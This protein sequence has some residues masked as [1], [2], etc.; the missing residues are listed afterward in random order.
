MPSFTLRLSALLLLLI[1][2]SAEARRYALILE[3]PPAARA[4]ASRA[5][6]YS[7]SGLDRR[8]RI[9]QAQASL[10][11]TLRSRRLAITGSVQVLLNAVFVEASADREAELRSLPGVRRVIFLPR[12]RPLLDRAVSLVNAPGAWNALG[13]VQNAG[14]GIK[15]GIIDTGI[16][17]THPAFQD[18]GLPVPSGFPICQGSDCAYTNHK[19]IVARSYVAQLAAGSPPGPQQSHPDDLSPADRSGHGTAVAMV[20]AGE[21]STGPA[22]AITGMAPKAYLGNYK[23]FGSPGVNGFSSGDVIMMALEQAL[24]DGMDIAVLSL[25]GPAFSGPLDTGAACG[26]NP[27]EVCDPEA[28]AVENAIQAGMMVVVAAGNSGDAGQ[29]GITLSTIGSPGTA[30]S[31]LTVGASSNSHAFV[32]SVQ[33]PGSDV[34]ANLR[35]F[36]AVFGDGALP[37]SPFTA[38]A[39][40]VTQLGD[41]GLACNAL[42]A[43]SLS[44]S[45]ALIQRGTCTFLVKVQNA[46]AAGATGVVIYQQNGVDALLAPGGLGGISIP[47]LMVGYTDG[48]ALKTFLDANPGHSVTLNPGLAEIDVSNGNQVASFSA[49]GPV[50]GSGA[51]KP[52]LLAVGTNLYMA[53]D[54][55]DP[56]ADLYDP[57][58]FTVASGTSFSAPMAAGGVALVKQ[59]H[60]SYTPGQLKSAVVNNATQDISESDGT[61]P[62]L[63]S[64]GAGKLNAGAA[65][66]NTVTIEPATL[67]F[68]LITS[69]STFP[70]TQQL[71][72]TNTGS[73]GL[74]LT[75]AVTPRSGAAQISLDTAS[76]SLP[77]GQ[78]RTV[79]ATLSGTRPGTGS[80][81]GFLTVQGAPSPLVVPY[82]YVVGDG[83]AYDIFS[84]FG[85]GFDGTVGQEH[86]DGGIAFKVVDRYGVGVPNLPVTFRAIQGGG[87]FSATYPRTDSN[88][89]AYADAFLGPTTGAQQ[90][91]GEVAGLAVSF[92]GIARLQPTI[93]TNGVVNAAS[94]QVGQGIAPGS[95][96][97][98][99]GSGLSDITDLETTTT[100]P[101][102]LAQVSVS[103]DVPSAGLSLPGRIY[104]VSPGQVNVQV[105]WGLGGQTSVQMKVNVGESVGKLYTVPLSD[106]APGVFEYNESANTRLAAA[107]D[108]GNRLI[109]SANPAVRGQT[110]QVFANG[111]GPV[112]HTPA[113]GA[114]APSDPL[115]RTQAPPTVTIG[116]QAA[117]V[118]FSG[119]A[120]GFA[121]LYQ[122]NVVIPAGLSAGTQTMTVTVNGLTSKTVNLPVQ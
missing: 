24:L 15:I 12:I 3:D 47:V 22:A 45:I 67:S 29:R 32:N 106:Y 96:I 61:N 35:N 21:T 51:L 72:I 98:I 75:L 85:D 115:A 87:R 122:L 101:L 119:L 37:A 112:D 14:N 46:L 31:A 102:S 6:L 44:G 91:S 54:R 7:T 42:Q 111:L 68:G 94:F 4:A 8:A 120:P 105:P 27:G 40:D 108:A 30:P 20:A 56:N 38:P 69:A 95:Y 88:G 114:P 9:S 76:F 90:F 92:S 18:D 43:G 66:T 23:V 60:P 25:G 33:V 110:I 11:G 113:D 74:S 48:A 41:D 63:I 107:L 116:G 16:D 53:A 109:G 2:V 100:L 71:K 73:A 78:S 118:S 50:I 64:M 81:E 83:V 70:A 89:I 86:P 55:T 49:R 79:T 52:D 103:F 19:V 82:Y 121:G 28:Q 57:S 65:V 10:R 34:P 62:S 58:G 26:G 36:A 1:P 5:G 93:S 84:L 39:R 59:A 80:Y 117:E 13:G 104:Y 97:S 17:V 77:A 99:F